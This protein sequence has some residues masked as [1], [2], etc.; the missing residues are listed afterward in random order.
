MNHYDHD[1]H[2]IELMN[3]SIKKEMFYDKLK[4][5]LKYSI[6]PIILLS[7]WYLGFIDSFILIL[8]Y[9]LYSIS[10]YINNIN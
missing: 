10:I 1:K 9:I 8:N 7:F 4:T 2:L 6:W 3:K 5:L